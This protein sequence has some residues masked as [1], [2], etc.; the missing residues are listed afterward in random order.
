MFVFIQKTKW[1]SLGFPITNIYIYIEL[2]PI[3][4]P[5]TTIMG[6]I[7]GLAFVGQ[8]HQVKPLDCLINIIGHTTI[9]I[10]TGLIYP[11][12]YP[13]IG[14]YVLFKHIKTIK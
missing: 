2:L 8:P 5:T 9:G 3:F 13:L 14:A 12:S 6:F 1:H 7:G 10:I 11:I 4:V